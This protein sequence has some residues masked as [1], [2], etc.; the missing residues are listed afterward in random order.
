ME[1]GK[2]MESPPRSYWMASSPTT[3]YPVLDEDINV[4]VAIIGGGFAGISAAYMLTKAGV[5]VAI[6]EADHILQGTTGHT[7]AKI[8]SQHYLIYDKL[9][10]K[11]G[12]ERAQQYANA[13]E[14]AIGIIEKIAKENNI[15]CDYIPQNAYVYTLEDKYVDKINDEEKAASLLGIKASCLDKIP[16][17]FTIKA[18]LQYEN[19]AQFNP[20]KFLIPLAKIITEKG[21]KIYEQSRIVDIEDDDGYT[22]I[23]NRGN[24]VRAEKLIIASHYPCYNKS[25][26]HFTRIYASR[27]Y[28]IA[29]KAKEKYPGGMYITAENSGFSYRSQPTDDGELI[30]VG[31]ESH[32]TGQGGDTAKHYEVLINQSHEKFTIE[33][34][35]YRWSA[36]DCMTMDELPLVGHYNSNTP[37]LYIATGFMKWGMTNS[38]ASATILKDLIVEGRSPWKDVYNPSRD[39]ILAST[40]NFVVENLNVAEKL[41][42]GKLMPASDPDD[43]EPGE[44]KKIKVDGQKSK[45]YRDEKGELHVVDPTCMH[46]GCEL[47]WN[48]AE[49]SW[50]CPCH[51]SRYALDGTIIEGPTVNP[52]NVYKNLS[53]IEKVTKDNF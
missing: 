20:L 31:G 41:L 24:K 4:E 11:M 22:I 5:K 28:V 7:T 32:K 47:S 33:D 46:M 23:T 19:Q 49:K 30:F 12:E 27:S 48:S 39:T 52:L 29:L 26:L 2:Y 6:L 16:L 53:T 50:D 10:K 17:P 25:A 18:A 13:N 37:N 34:I 38:I 21:N 15:E 9:V 1:V 3:H 35:P 42:E 43:M 51:G 45:A 40:K 14:A 36:Q 8:T 44:G